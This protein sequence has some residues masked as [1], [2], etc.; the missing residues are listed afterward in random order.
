MHAYDPFIFPISLGVLILEVIAEL[1]RVAIWMSPPRKSFA[2]V[3]LCTI[4]VSQML[5][6][7]T[8]FSP[9]SVIVVIAPFLLSFLIPDYLTI[10]SL[11][12]LKFLTVIATGLFGVLGFVLVLVVINVNIVAL[13]HYGIPY[14]PFGWYELMHMFLRKVRTCLFGIS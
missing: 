6:R 14:S 11:R 10:H 12:I 7:N 3:A 5:T 1:M 2:I 4:T 8:L 13:K 9:I